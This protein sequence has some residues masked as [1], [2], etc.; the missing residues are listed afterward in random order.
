[1]T[2]Y[3]PHSPKNI[4]FQAVAEAI[5]RMAPA[6]RA[7]YVSVIGYSEALLEGLSGPLT[8][9]QREDIEA[10]RVSGWEALSN[11]NDILDVMLLMSGEIEY[12]K[13]IFPIRQMLNDVLRDVKR[14]YY[15]AQEKLP[16]VA[17]IN[18]DEDANIEGDEH[19]LRQ[20]ILGLINNAFITDSE[21]QVSLKAY[22]DAEAKQVCIQIQDSCH[23]SSED[24]Y[25]YFFEPSWMSKLESGK[26]RQMQWQSYL[27]HH[28]VDAHDGEI[29]VGR[30]EPTVE[31]V[32][33]VV[34]IRLPLADSVTPSA[35]EEK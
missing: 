3:K 19:R 5:V 26:W 30:T 22:L 6:Y 17:N 23:V 2:T 4:D 15:Q 24:D 9:A 16:L 1:M 25:T 32:G 13:Q 18:I 34:E 10:I 35:D 33:T 8:N 29:S 12:N 7:P 27:A 31:P 28:F 20:A 14:T 21:G 11:L